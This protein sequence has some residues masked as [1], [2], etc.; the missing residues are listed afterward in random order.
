MENGS[1]ESFFSRLRD[2]L[3]NVEEFENL[4][5]ARWFAKRRREEHNEE[6]PHSSLSANQAN[7][8]ANQGHPLL[9]PIR[10]THFL[11]TRQR[12]AAEDRRPRWCA[13]KACSRFKVTRSKA[14]QG[15]PLF[16]DATAVGSAGSQ[17]AVGQ[18]GTPTFCR[19]DAAGQRRIAGRGGARLRRAVD[20]R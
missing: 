18:S 4:V 15:H 20:S 10:D 11:Q 19:C 16:A 7:Q 17:A 6:R 1:A 14:N 13:A 8:S 12:W 2:E 5:E 3:L 9:A